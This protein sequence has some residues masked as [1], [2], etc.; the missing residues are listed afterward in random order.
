MPPAASVQVV[1]IVRG[2]AGA[3]IPSLAA[4]PQGAGAAYL[5]RAAMVDASRRTAGFAAAA[6]ALGVLATLALPTP[7]RPDD[8]PH[9]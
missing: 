8:D 2:S 7:R 3:A 1:E 4:D 5:A 9:L 6:L